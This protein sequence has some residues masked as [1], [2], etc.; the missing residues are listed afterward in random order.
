MQVEVYP[1]FPSKRHRFS[2]NL[3]SKN[4]FF[5]K[6]ESK[7]SPGPRRKR[8]MSEREKAH[9]CQKKKLQ[10]ES[11]AQGPDTLGWSFLPFGRRGSSGVDRERSRFSVGREIPSIRAIC[12]LLICRV[13]Y[14]SSAD[15]HF[16][17]PPGQDSGL[18][19]CRLLWQ[20]QCLP[21]DAPKDSGAQTR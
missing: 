1:S 15:C 13:R 18:C 11:S 21:A 6:M 8:R 3:D 19:T 17:I 16:W 10:P 4:S 9:P 7:S 5:Y 20:W 12:C 2:V 14:F